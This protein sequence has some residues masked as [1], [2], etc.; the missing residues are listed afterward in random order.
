MKL[1]GQ[2]IVMLPWFDSDGM[3][4][5]VRLTFRG[6]MDARELYKHVRVYIRKEFNKKVDKQ[7]IKANCPILN[8]YTD[9]KGKDRTKQ[10][11][12]SDSFMQLVDEWIREVESNEDEDRA[13]YLLQTGNPEGTVEQM[14]PLP[15]TT[16]H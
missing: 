4:Q 3:K 10:V 15:D 13:D 8:E 12:D 16:I 1:K 6:E 2:T 11:S 5:W 7:W 14:R 9:D